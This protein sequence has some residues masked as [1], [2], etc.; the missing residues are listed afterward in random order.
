[1]WREYSKSDIGMG[2]CAGE[3]VSPAE[4]G[5]KAAEREIFAAL[6]FLDNGKHQE[7]LDKAF[8][9]MSFAIEGLVKLKNPFVQGADKIADEF[10]K[11]YCDTGVFYDP[12][13]G[14]R[15]ANLFF[16]A[17]AEQGRPMR[18]DQARQ[19]LEEAQLFIDAAHAC[20][21]RL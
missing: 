12:F 13:A 8:A 11:L 16:K 21:G 17:L 3:L 5:L 2:E 9:A 1:M 14:D 4:F 18:P 19:R 20:L 10:K 7:A 15:F 6:L